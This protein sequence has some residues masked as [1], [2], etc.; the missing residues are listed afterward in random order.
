MK[1]NILITSIFSSLISMQAFSICPSTVGQVCDPDKVTTTAIYAGT[2]SCVARISVPNWPVV[3]I[4]QNI[5]EQTSNYATLYK[6]VSD[7]CVGT[8]TN[9]PVFSYSCTAA[10]PFKRWNTVTTKGACHD[11]VIPPPPSCG[12]NTCNTYLENIQGSQMS[13]VMGNAASY[14]GSCSVVVQSSL[15]VSGT[16]NITCGK[17]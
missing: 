8:T 16:Y 9:C 10:V 1:F 7:N 13:S 12:A 2:A 5:S 14:C 6:A 11:V 4:T 17:Q 15:T 3:T